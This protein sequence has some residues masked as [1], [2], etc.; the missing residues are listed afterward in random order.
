MYCEFCGK[1]LK[2]EETCTC[3]VE[4]KANTENANQTD[5][6]MQSGGDSPKKQ[7]MGKRKKQIVLFGA[8]IAVVLAVIIFIMTRPKKIELANY[9]EKEPTI[10]G[11]NGRGVLATE[12]IF[13]YAG[14]LEDLVSDKEKQ[15]AEG[16]EELDEDTSDEELASMLAENFAELETDDMEAQEIQENIEISFE[17]NGKKASEAKGLSNGDVIEIKV[18][19]KQSVNKHY[20]KKFVSGS[21]EYKVSGLLEG[22]EVSVF[23][24]E[25]TEVIFQG[26]NGEGTVQIKTEGDIFDM[27]SI[28]EEEVRSDY[29][30]G[31]KVILK[32]VYDGQELAEAGYYLKEEE[33]EYTVKGL[34]DYVNSLEDIPSKEFERLKQLSLEKMKDSLDAYWSVSGEVTFLEAGLLVTKKSDPDMDTNY[35]VVVGK[36]NTRDNEEMYCYCCF[37]DVSV[38]EEQELFSYGREIKSAKLP[39]YRL[40]REKL[41]EILF[42]NEDY[43]YMK[44]E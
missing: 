2:E 34:S 44:I 22:K 26:V 3:Q 16:L 10:T 41:N 28:E 25:M 6:G 8:G 15:R 30:N 11:V 36:Y 31:E 33:K 29:S 13:D 32:A 19:S 27:V 23:D 21:Y 17:I 43:E 1:E 5:S 4:R 7:N 40:D 35:L 37:T 14:F 18:S 12:E 42:E 9:I 39:N 38:N 20:H 24:K